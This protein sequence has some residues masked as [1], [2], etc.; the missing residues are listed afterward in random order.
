MLNR[1]SLKRLKA[2]RSILLKKTTTQ[3]ASLATTILRMTPLRKEFVLKA[4][5]FNSSLFAN[6]LTNDLVINQLTKFTSFK[7]YVSYVNSP[8]RKKF[9]KARQ[10]ATCNVA[11]NRVE[12]SNVDRTFNKTSRVIALRSRG[13]SLP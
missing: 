13:M 8:A 10:K 3:P 9:A 6:S 12:A 4:K 1:D 11:P 2:I 7:S 5:I